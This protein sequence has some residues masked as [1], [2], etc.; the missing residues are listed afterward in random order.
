ML[1]C[2]LKLTLFLLFKANAMPKAG[3]GLSLLYNSL[4]ISCKRIYK[5][6][7]PYLYSTLGL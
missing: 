3:K 7:I 6:L 4:I 5:V 2:L 1:V